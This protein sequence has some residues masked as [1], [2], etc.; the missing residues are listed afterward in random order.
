MGHDPRDL[1]W[2]RRYEE[3]DTPW[4]KGAPAP[5]LVEYLRRGPIVGRVLV[6]GCGKGHE[7]RALGDQTG[8]S[9]MGL[10]LSPSALRVARDL[11][12]EAGLGARVKF[13]EADFFELP[14]D[15]KETFDWL[16]EHTCFCAIEPARRSAYVES[17]TA[18]LAAG[19]KIFGIFYLNPDTEEGPPFAVSEK[20]LSGLFDPHFI[21]LEEWVPRESFPGREGRELVR[22]L[23]KRQ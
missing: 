16:V 5:V 22:I 14:A 10:D 8:A 18:A 17:A 9:V 11:A 3:N 21:L 7:V 13:V 12:V 23:Q 2:Q 15:L 4:D 19:G 20:E 1:E 6:P